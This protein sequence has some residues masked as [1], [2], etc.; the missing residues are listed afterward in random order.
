MEGSIQS[1]G[2][3][4]SERL[5]EVNPNRPATAQC[6]CSIGFHQL[7]YLDFSQL[8]QTH[9][10]YTHLCKWTWLYATVLYLP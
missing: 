4:R 2:I 5:K 8:S 6:G 9:R 7:I 1:R 10:Q 3:K